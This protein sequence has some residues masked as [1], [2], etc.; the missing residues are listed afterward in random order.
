MSLSV[1]KKDHPNYNQYTIRN[2]YFR[3]YRQCQLPGHHHWS[4]TF[5]V[6]HVVSLSQWI[7]SCI[8]TYVFELKY[9]LGTLKYMYSMCL[10]MNVYTCPKFHGHGWYCPYFAP[11]QTAPWSF[12]TYSFLAS[13]LSRNTVS[14]KISF[15]FRFKFAVAFEGKESNWAKISFFYWVNSSILSF[16]RIVSS[17]CFA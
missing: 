17:F 10:A 3:H 1:F 11:C 4:C 7:Q 2:F 13:S 15:W 16:Q 12:N 8:Q 9:F 14:P 6:R 5:H